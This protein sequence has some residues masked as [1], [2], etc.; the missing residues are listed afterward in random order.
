M[1]DICI[2]KARKSD[3]L[4][5]QRLL[6]TYFLDMEGLAPEDFVLA[7]IDGKITGCAALIKSEFHGNNFLEIHSIA[8]HPNFRGK[9]V[10][11]RLVKY[12]LTTTGGSCCD[13]YVR[14]TAPIFFEKLN[15]KK[16][17]NSEKLSL[18]KDCENCEHF[19]K[20]TQHAMKYSCK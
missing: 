18:W 11:T 14:T 16:V 20:C 6:S 1:R 3:L 13:L 7:E 19:E 15:F 8:V 5:I 4:A 17:E 12:L 10:G 9:G 2:R